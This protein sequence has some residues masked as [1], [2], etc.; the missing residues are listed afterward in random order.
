M[1]ASDKTR[2]RHLRAFKVLS[3]I[4]RPI[5]YR[6]YR[7]TPVPVTGVE[8]PFLVF[9]NHNADLDA[10]L[11]NLAFKEQMYFVASEHIFRKGFLSKLL[12]RYFDPIS[13]L[14]GGTEASA[15]MEM[16]RRLRRGYNICVFAEGD[17]SF[18]G[19]TCPIPPATGKLAKAAGVTVITYK[20][21]GGYLTTPRWGKKMRHGE[22]LGYTVNVYSKEQIK[23][24]SADEVNAVLASDLYEDAYARQVEHPVRYKGKDRAEWLE[25]AL[26]ICPSCGGIGTLKSQKN[27][28]YCDCGLNLEYT[29]YG[30]LE[31]NVPYKT[32]THWDNWQTERLSEIAKEPGDASLFT[33]ENVRLICVMPDHKEETIA[34]G[35][36]T[37]NREYIECGGT[38]LFISDISAMA[39]Y[40]RA[41]VTFTHKDGHY[42]LLSVPPFCGRKYFQLFELLK[43]ETEK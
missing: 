13:R 5:F 41:N 9:S 23:Q 25:T 2:A 21:E 26:Y 33:D 37:M 8:G 3:A 29:E 39:L 42:E 11:V 43:K 4:I 1:K 19:L 22:M 18:N 38:K 17:R 30:Y 10:V 24:M 6:M 14:K 27:E 28:F 16:L 12:V 34:Q 20:L 36:L 40:G 31:G 35:T 7:Y 15:A 32:V